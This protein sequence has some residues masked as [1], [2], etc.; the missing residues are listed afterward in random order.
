MGRLPDKYEARVADE[1]QQRCKTIFARCKPQRRMANG[2]EC[3]PVIHGSALETANCLPAVD[4]LPI[5]ELQLIQPVIN[6]AL[7]E[8]FLMR[9]RLAQLAFV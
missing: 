5:L 9:T 7:R 4:E 8:Q 2:L 6:A 1:I 3:V